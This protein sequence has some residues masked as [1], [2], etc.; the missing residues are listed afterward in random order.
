VELGVLVRGGKMPEM[1]EEQ[2]Q[3]LIQR[4]VLELA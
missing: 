2:F 1:V 3:R 4:G